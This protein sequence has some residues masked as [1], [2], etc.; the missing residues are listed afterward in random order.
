MGGARCHVG[1]VVCSLFAWRLNGTIFLRAVV[2][3]FHS[4]FQTPGSGGFQ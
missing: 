1:R 3:F 4:V 2:V